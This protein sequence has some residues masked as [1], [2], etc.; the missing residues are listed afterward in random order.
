MSIIHDSFPLKNEM[1]KFKSCSFQRSLYY[2]QA[3]GCKKN[4]TDE[5]I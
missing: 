4:E 2:V 1:N 3:C 5:K